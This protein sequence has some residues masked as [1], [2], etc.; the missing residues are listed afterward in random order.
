MKPVAPS[1]SA[2]VFRR[3]IVVRNPFH[4]VS[5]PFLATLYA[6]AYKPDRGPSKLFVAKPAKALFRALMRLGMGG[7]GRFRL[8]L[9]GGSR[10]AS[11]NARN[12]QF[13]AIYQ[14]H[15]RPVYEPEVSAL[16]DLLVPDDGCF[17]DIGANWGWF[18]LLV[19][20]RPGFRGHIHAFE[21]MPETFAD[22]AG[23]VREMG[24]EDRI[25]CHGMAL[26]DREGSARMG[27]PGSLQSGLA[28]LDRAG[29]TTIPLN[30]LDRMDLPPPNVIKMDVEDH[31]T[32][33][34]RGAE[35]SIA[36]ARPF[37][38]FENWLNRAKP[39]TTLDALAWF[40]DRNY[41]FYSAGWETEIAGCVVP[42]PPNRTDKRSVLAVVPFLLEQRFHLPAQMN[43][44]AAP[45]ERL[46]E[47]RQRVEGTG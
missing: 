23:V 1:S 16:M 39:A 14:Q 43:V 37:V 11:F 19:A 41:R 45:L 33:V 46:D 27:I 28:R 34:L 15:F 32:E 7:Y 10:D 4:P 20:S 18:S 35:A 25:T 44:L 21:P 26:S 31:E 22:L 24:L 5:V 40:N 8:D 2:S 29:R 17:L 6:T 47:L 42:S 9:P 38:V 3:E 12:T 13:G 30:T 36:A